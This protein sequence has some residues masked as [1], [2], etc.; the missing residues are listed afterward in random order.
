LN[1]LPLTSTV[2]ASTMVP[3]PSNISTLLLLMMRPYT[4]TSRSSSL[5]FAATSLVQSNVGFSG[6]CQTAQDEHTSPSNQARNSLRT[7]T[8]WKRLKG[9]LEGHRDGAWK[10]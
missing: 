1:C 7:H 4:P 5:F 10:L 8:A 3:R 9:V 6:I 2:W